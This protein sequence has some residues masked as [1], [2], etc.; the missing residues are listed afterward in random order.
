MQKVFIIFV[1]I[2]LVLSLISQLEE[3]KKNPAKF[4]QDKFK[5]FFIISVKD[6]QKIGIN[7]NDDGNQP[8]ATYKDSNNNN[9]E[10]CY[11]TETKY[12]KNTSKK[13]AYYCNQG[14]DGGEVIPSKELYN[15]DF[16]NYN[17]HYGRA[18]L[19]KPLTNTV[20]NSAVNIGLFNIGPITGVLQHQ[21]A[22]VLTE[23][24]NSIFED[25]FYKTNYNKLY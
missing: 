14:I 18:V 24:F 10:I 13:G 21:S 16:T 3:I 5:E 23:F 7:E 19:G 2:L 25:I 6:R 11:S 15:L 8:K 20:I 17:I 4:I 22:L 9:N 12:G 1:L